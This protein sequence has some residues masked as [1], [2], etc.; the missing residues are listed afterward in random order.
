MSDNK[1][2]KYNR[3]WSLDFSIP[4]TFKAIDIQWLWYIRRDEKRK[5][6][7]RT[8]V[9]CEIDGLPRD[10]STR[11]MIEKFLELKLIT[12]YAPYKKAPLYRRYE[13][14]DIGNALLD[15]AIKSDAEQIGGV[16]FI[17]PDFDPASEPRPF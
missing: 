3:N 6:D 10:K 8:W 12:S 15:K 9:I 13:L 14:T 2:P 16:V 7:W 5:K 17:D 1:P 11:C 4:T